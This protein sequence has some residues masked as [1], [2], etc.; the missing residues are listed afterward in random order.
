MNAQVLA[1]LALDSQ[2]LCP[3]WI[4]LAAEWDVILGNAECNFVERGFHQRFTV[5]ETIA[6]AKQDVDT[7][8]AKDAANFVRSRQR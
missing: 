6:S 5:A 1:L 7:S 3:K 4:S 2:S 8:P